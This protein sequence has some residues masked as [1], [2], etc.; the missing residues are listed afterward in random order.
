M[1]YAVDLDELD[2]VIGDIAA[3]TQRL[4]ARLEEANARVRTLHTTWS[5]A[6]ADEHNLA[7]QR[8]AASEQ[9]MREGLAVMRGIAATA[10]SNYTRA[11]TANSTMWGSL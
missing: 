7:H 10:H 11:V 3:F 4:E 9:Q 2:R 6:A 1:K 5:G 8:W